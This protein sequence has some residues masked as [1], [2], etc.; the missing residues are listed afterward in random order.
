MTAIKWTVDESIPAITGRELTGRYLENHPQAGPSVDFGTIHVD[1]KDRRLIVKLDSRPVLR[2]IVDAAIAAEAE[3]ERIEAERMATNV[4]G[5]AELQ[6]AIDAEQ[7]YRHDFTRMMEDEGNDGVN[8]PKHPLASS[9]DLA[10]RFPRAAVYI[11]AESYSFASHWAKAK[12]GEEA[13]EIIASGGSIED[14]EAT[15]DNWLE[16]NGV[17]VD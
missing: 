3:A 17:Y 12:A 5:L 2:Q 15:L 7:Q 4:P 1:R 14:A 11:S 13:M 10:T 16:D 9:A 6:A 8:P